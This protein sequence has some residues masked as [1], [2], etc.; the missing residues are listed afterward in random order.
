MLFADNIVL[1]DEARERLNVK[2]EKLRHILESKGFKLSRSK[3][4]YLRC[5]VNG[6]EGVEDEVTLGGEAIPKVS[7]T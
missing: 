7:S 1:I 3:T 5:E 6:V 4:K 2:L